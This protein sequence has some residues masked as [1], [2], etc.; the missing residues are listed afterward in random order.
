MPEPT[1][2]LYDFSSIEELKK[3][4]EESLEKLNKRNSAE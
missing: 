2:E 4:A 3:L 1:K